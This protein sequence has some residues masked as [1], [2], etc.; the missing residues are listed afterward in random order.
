MFVKLCTSIAKMLMRDRSA[1]FF[2]F[3]FPVMMAGIFGLAVKSD[4]K[5]LKVATVRTGSDPVSQLLLEQLKLARDAQGN[6]S[7]QLTSTSSE[8]VVPGLFESSDID[9]ALVVPDLSEGGTLT[10]IY[11]EKSPEHLGRAQTTLRALVQTYNL[12]SAGGMETVKLAAKGLRSAKGLGSFDFLLPTLLMF[13]V[14]FGT[15]T[16]TAGR[17]ANL[18]EGGIFKRLQVTPLKPRLFLAAETLVRVLISFIQAGLVIAVAVVGYQAEIAG[19][20]LWAFLLVGIGTIVFTNLGVL[21]AVRAKSPD[22]ASSMGALIGALFFFTGGGG[23]SEAMPKGVTDLFVNLPFALLVDQIK[24]VILDGTTPFADRN[25]SLLLLGWLILTVGATMKLFT[26][27]EDK[28]KKP[29]GT[30]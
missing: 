2:M 11:D 22:A 19:N 12:Q 16:A 3:L 7:F 25:K 20:I 28:P 26:F 23:I 4:V 24:T 8:A 15:M 1:M 10:L 17:F 14:V 29:R 18:Q 27:A 9:V 30:K 5:P 13:G 21:I 6:R